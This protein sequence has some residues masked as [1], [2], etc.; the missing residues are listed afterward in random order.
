MSTD[1]ERNSEPSKNEYECEFCGEHFNSK[2]D[3]NDHLLAEH[4]SKVC[5]CC[6][7]P[8]E[9]I[10]SYKCKF[11]GE[12]F[13]T[14]HRLPEKHECKGLEEHKK[15]ARKDGNISYMESKKHK[16]FYSGE[17]NKAESNTYLIT[18]EYCGKGFETKDAYNKHAEEEHGFGTCSECGTLLKEKT[19]FTCSE[20]GEAFCEEHKSPED[21]NCS[22]RGYKVKD[23]TKEVSEE[24]LRGENIG[25]K[26]KNNKKSI[27][28][29]KSTSKSRSSLSGSKKSKKLPWKKILV[30]FIIVLIYISISNPSVVKDNSPKFLSGYV[31]PVVDNLRG[32]YFSV[33]SEAS[34][35]FNQSSKSS[36]SLSSPPDINTNELEKEIHKLINEK[37]SEHDLAKLSWDEELAEIARGHSEYMVKTDHFSHKDLKG[38]G[39]SYRYE[40]HEYNCKVSISE[41]KYMRGAENIFENNRYSSTTYSGGEPISHDWNTQEEIAESTVEGWMNS[42]GHRENILEPYW[43][44]EGIGVAID[45][46]TDKIYITQNFC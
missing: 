7:E 46:E 36:S 5:T 22:R 3:L 12:T 37:R 41:S 8:F 35:I 27:K 20:C 14:E 39:F 25:I 45:Y 19:P 32:I 33:S 29:S 16:K 43:Y 23:K 42:E 28:S 30:F 15:K 13:C 31:N 11:C 40:E 4:S 1:G 9:S 38:R 26:N 21:H 44:N 6:A 10:I 17:R 24:E 34:E 18:C 2:E